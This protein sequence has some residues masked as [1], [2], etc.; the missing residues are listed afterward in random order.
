MLRESCDHHKGKPD[1]AV[2]VDFNCQLKERIKRWVPNMPD[3][4]VDQELV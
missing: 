3:D 1:I 4:S 2:I